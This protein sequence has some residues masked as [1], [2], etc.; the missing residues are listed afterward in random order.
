LHVPV[1]LVVLLLPSLVEVGILTREI[2][3]NEPLGA[4]VVV[5]NLVLQVLLVHFVCHKLPMDAR[6]RQ[7][8]VTFDIHIY[9]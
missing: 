2:V 1:I 3:R 9:A 6:P 5:E 4:E 8:S 7:Y